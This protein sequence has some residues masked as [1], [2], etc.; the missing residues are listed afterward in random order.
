MPPM[1]TIVMIIETHIRTGQYHKLP[2]QQFGH[3][4]VL[5]YNII[6][7]SKLPIMPQKSAYDSQILLIVS[8]YL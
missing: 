2:Q 3:R 5:Y 7:I 1:H 8:R 6:I 4:L